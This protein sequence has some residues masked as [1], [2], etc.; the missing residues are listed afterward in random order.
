MQWIWQSPGDLVWVPWATTR[1]EEHNQRLARG[2][3]LSAFG[4]FLLD[5][6]QDQIFNFPG[7]G[8]TNLPH[9]HMLCWK[10]ESRSIVVND[11]I[12]PNRIATKCDPISL[13]SGVDN[14]TQKPVGEHLARPHVAKQ[15]EW[16]P[17]S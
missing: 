16:P 7:S 15:L 9:I 13:L 14:G 11:S 12:A 4:T 1:I 8:V 6:L 5:L 17:G 3:G 10:G 2:I